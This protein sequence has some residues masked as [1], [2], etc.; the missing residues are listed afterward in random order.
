MKKSTKLL[1]KVLG[2]IIV[3]G[4]LFI[5]IISPISKKITKRHSPEIIETYH[6]NNLELEVFYCS[7][8][9]K[10]RTIFGNLVPFNEVWRT[11]ANEATTFSTNKVLNIANTIVPAGKYTLWTIPG[12]NQWN[13]IFNS[14]IYGWGIRFKNGKASREPEYDIASI[15]IPVSKSTTISENLSITFREIDDNLALVILWDNTTVSIPIREVK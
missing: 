12:K 15:T 7:P 3:L 6:S 14:K 13:I 4:L 2:S 8:S 10:G 11:G 1:L 9:K 5:F